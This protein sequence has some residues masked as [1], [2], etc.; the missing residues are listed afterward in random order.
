[1]K[2]I[3]LLCLWLLPGLVMG[4]P[5]VEQSIQAINDKD[6]SILAKSF[7]NVVDVTIN[8][9]QSTYSRSQAAIVLEKFFSTNDIK[10]FTLKHKGTPPDNSSV[11][12]IGNLT[13]KADTEYRLY[14]FFKKK[15]VGFVL[16]EIRIEQ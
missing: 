12:V 9:E 10:S 6:V 14:L 8:N 2:W 3:C 4:Q 1:M 15:D 16:Q 7:D 5:V 11:Y 13:T